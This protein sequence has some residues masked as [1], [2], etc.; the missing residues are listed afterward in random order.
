MAELT[1]REK[2]AYHAGE[3][4]K[5]RGWF[6]LSPFDDDKETLAFYRGYDGL[7]EKS[8]LVTPEECRGVVTLR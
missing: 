3:R 5:Q 6:R 8:Q 7:P 4:A 2:G 1:L